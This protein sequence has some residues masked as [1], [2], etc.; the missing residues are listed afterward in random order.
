MVVLF[1]S[2]DSQGLVNPAGEVLRAHSDGWQQEYER[3][4]NATMDML[5]QPDRLVVWVGL[6]PMRDGDF[7][8]RLAQINGIY[9]NAAAA[10]DG[11][12]YLDTWPM[13]SDDSGQ[14][15]AYR[16]ESGD[17][18]LVREPDGVHMTRAGGDILADAVMSA[19]DEYIELDPTATTAPQ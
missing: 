2:N 4:V 10:H 13:F 3:R 1:G 5:A 15:V 7:S 12:V 9:R 6:P 8:E 14:Y 18:E 16:E 19:I 17:A 11:V